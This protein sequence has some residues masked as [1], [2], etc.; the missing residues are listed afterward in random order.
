M[1]KGN[2]KLKNIK[3]KQTKKACKLGFVKQTSIDANYTSTNK[4]LVKF[5]IAIKTKKAEKGQI[6]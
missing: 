6:I 3:S 4:L 5:K 2:R 1:D